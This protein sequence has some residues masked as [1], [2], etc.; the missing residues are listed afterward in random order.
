MPTG[1]LGASQA[2]PT[3]TIHVKRGDT[4]FAIAQRHAVPGVTIYQMMI[5][6]QRAN[7][8]AFIHENINLVKA[9]GSLSM[10]GHDALTAISY[11]EARRIFHKQAATL[12]LYRPR[13]AAH[14]T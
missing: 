7:P 3:K 10:P 14:P 1:S 11:R 4:M 2:A 6:L 13:S 12:D 5:A 8:S 9:G